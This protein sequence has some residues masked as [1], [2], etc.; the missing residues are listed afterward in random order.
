MG[1]VALI[2]RLRQGTEPRAAELIRSGPPFDPATVGFD[3]HTVFLSATEVV[4]VF[5]GREV[6]WA[7]DKLVG[8]P[9]QWLLTEALDEWTNI[10]DGPPRIGR[11]EYAWERA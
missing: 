9:F 7:I 3:R 2:A 4:F 6:E 5:E 8:D 11:A 1:Q 10:I